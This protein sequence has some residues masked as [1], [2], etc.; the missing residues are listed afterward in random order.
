[1]D[2]ISNFTMIMAAYGY[3]L[4]EFEPIPRNLS[5]VQEN[6]LKPDRVVQ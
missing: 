1:M 2:T 4:N 3:V 6:S 5:N